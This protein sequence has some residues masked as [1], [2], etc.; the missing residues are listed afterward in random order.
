MSLAGSLRWPAVL[1]VAAT[2]APGAARSEE[3]FVGSNAQAGLETNDNVSLVPNSPGTV[4]T[5]SLSTTINAL[6]RQANAATQLD[7]ILSAIQQSGNGAADRV[8]G[9]LGV[10]QSVNVPRAGFNVAASLAQDFN[11]D[12]ISADVTVGRGRRRTIV[13]SAGASYALSERLSASAQVSGSRT[14]YGQELTQASDF[15][16][17]GVSASLSYLLSETDTFTAQASHS[18]Y[19]TLSDS[20]RSRTDSVNLGISHALSERASASLNLGTYRTVT[21][22][23]GLR[24][25]CPLQVSFCQ[26]GLVPYIVVSERLTSSRDGLDY[27]GSL[28]YRIDETTALSA[29]AGREKYN[30][31]LN[32]KFDERSNLAFVASRQQAP[33]ATGSEVRNQILSISANHGL[34]PTVSV[35]ASYAQ[36]RSWSEAVNTGGPAGQRS[37]SVSLTNELTRDLALQAG[38][39]RTLADALAGA[40]GARSNSFNVALTYTWSRLD[41]L[42]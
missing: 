3:W 21:S 27:G 31:S 32:M 42:R 35:A 23:L 6:R 22:N 36:S 15:R 19:R 18:G 5:V 24:L 7:V 41:G 2:L 4:N 28:A 8:D 10:T 26:A 17:T 20:N 16:T 13:L 12:V 14:G 1:T 11:S 34:S 9:R 40:G 38:Y 25:A 29:G 30:V 39:R 37:L 33:S